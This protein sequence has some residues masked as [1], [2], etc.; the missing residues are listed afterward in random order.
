MIS[1]L[2]YESIVRGYALE[3]TVSDGEQSID[4]LGT[5]NVAPVN[6]SDPVFTQTCKC[7]FKDV[8]F[9]QLEK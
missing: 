5:V 1:V 2:D 9:F 8:D 6:E 7:I 3:I 4:I